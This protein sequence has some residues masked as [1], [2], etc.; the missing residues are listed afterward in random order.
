MTHSETEHSVQ[1]AA[2]GAERSGEGGWDKEPKEKAA[3]L[4]L[5]QTF[6]LIVTSL[7]KWAQKG[8]TARSL[9]TE[10]PRIKQQTRPFKHQRWHFTFT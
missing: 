3:H 9:L 1:S 5:R 6:N 10:M 7:P 2:S 4:S 8:F